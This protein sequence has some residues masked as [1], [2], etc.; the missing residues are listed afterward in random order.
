MYAAVWLLF[1]FLHACYFVAVKCEHFLVFDNFSIVLF[2]LTRKGN[3]YCN[4]AVLLSL[5]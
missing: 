4:N 5:W 2:L 1:A 3:T